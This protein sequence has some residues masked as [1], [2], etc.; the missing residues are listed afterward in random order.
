M[1][2]WTASSSQYTLKIMTIVA[3]IFTPIMLAY[4]IW[5]FWVFK[6]RVTSDPKDL[7]Y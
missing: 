4:Q 5:N 6:K 7:V 2:I 1:T 3:L